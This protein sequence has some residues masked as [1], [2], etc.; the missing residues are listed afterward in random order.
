[1]KSRQLIV[2]LTS[3]IFLFLATSC[4]KKEATNT[5]ENTK[6]EKKTTK[7]LV[8]NDVK[9]KVVLKEGMQVVKK[10][11]AFWVPKGWTKQASRDMW[12]DPVTHSSVN[13]I[14]ENAASYKL[15]AYLTL[16]L[17]NMKKAIKTYKLIKRETKTINGNKIGMLL[18]EFTMQGMD[19]KL[20][21]VV[22]DVKGMKYVLS[23]GGPKSSFKSLE[24]TFNKVISSIVKL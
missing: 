15:E 23:I 5:A 19:I 20:Y 3:L 9:K 1:M 16:S 13:V 11:V 7:D 8:K 12:I 17:N 24:A 6:V 14:T 18:G 10:K 4:N 22:I 21:S 2:L